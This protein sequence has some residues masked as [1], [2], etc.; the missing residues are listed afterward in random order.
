MWS[1]RCACA[2]L[3]IWKKMLCKEVVSGRVL[4]MFL[5]SLFGVYLTNVFETE[6][7]SGETLVICKLMLCKEVVS[8]AVLPLVGMYLYM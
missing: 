4:V 5:L 2:S 7:W 1:D 6:G 3:T 8:D